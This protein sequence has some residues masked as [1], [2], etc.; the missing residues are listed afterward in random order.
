[1]PV[2]LPTVLIVLIE[3]SSAPEPRQVEAWQEAL[4]AYPGGGRIVRAWAGLGVVP[5]GIDYPT[6]AAAVAVLGVPADSPVVV[7]EAYAVP[8]P[9]LME[10]LVGEAL[11]SPDRVVD[12]RA[13]P[14]E[15]TRVSDRQRGYHLED[16]TDPSAAFLQETRYPGSDDE[17]DDP[18]DEDDEDDTDEAEGEDDEG[19]PDEAEGDRAED[20]GPGR[21]DAAMSSHDLRAQDGFVLQARVSGACCATRAA[22]VAALDDALLAEPSEVSGNALL[23]AAA[24]RGID[25]VVAETGVVSLP[26]RLGWDARIEGLVPVAADRPVEWDPATHPALLPGSALGALAQ[27]LG[28]RPAA[29]AD[30]ATAADTPFLSIV[31]RTQGRRLHCLEDMLTCLAGQGDRDFEVLLMCHRTTT[32]ELAAVRSVVDSAPGWL[33]SRVRVV[34]AERPGRAAPLNDGFTAARGRYVVALD[35]DDTVLA[36][37]VATFKAAAAEHDGRVL[38][39]VAVRQDVAPVGGIDTLCAVSVDDPFREWPMDFSLVDHLVANYS[40]FMTVAFP[41]G[42]F[43]DLGLRFDESLDTTEDWDLLVRCA[44]VLGVASVREVT[45]VY[46]WWVHTGS[47]RAVHS[48]AEWAAARKRV[49]SA[50]EQSVLLMSPEE[51]QRTVASLRKAHKDSNT[52]HRMARRLATSQHHV[53]LQMDEV[54]AAHDR[55]VEASHEWRERAKAAQDKVQ[56]VRERLRKRH[57]RQLALLREADLLL[58]ERPHARPATSIVD[59]SPGDLEELVARLRAEPVMRSRAGRRTR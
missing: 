5:A 13:L 3:R 40:P 7:A 19:D 36:H 41:R 9:H 27:Q 11:L 42:A 23:D 24:A 49:Q 28:L 51:T 55:A 12:A 4:E 20:V 6:P 31:T 34:E 45:S 54:K 56:E 30:R 58:A 46:R 18:D 39:A 52:A 26:L 35:D 29:S 8:G 22:H 17:H 16:D 44:A 14:V 47:S 2:D 48:K 37:Y 33:R 38:R 53:I 15:L 10:R 59:L 50:F 57:A 21:D 43:H 32:Q 25:V 1:M